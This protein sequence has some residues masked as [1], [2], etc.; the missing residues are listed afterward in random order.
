[1]FSP[2]GFLDTLLALFAFWR[3]IKLVS[4]SLS[5]SASLLECFDLVLSSDCRRALMRVDFADI[6]DRAELAVL[7]EMLLRTDWKENFRSGDIRVDSVKEGLLAV[8]MD[9]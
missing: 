4:P 9:S 1:M 8:V 2:S 3:V 5:S 6:F 7:V